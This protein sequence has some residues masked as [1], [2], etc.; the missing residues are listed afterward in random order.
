MSKLDIIS[1]TDIKILVDKFYEKVVA[2]PVIGFIFNDI[3]KLSW[4]K[5]IPVM[6]TFWSSVLLETR[7][8]TGNPMEKHLEL[9][10][11][12]PLTQLHFEQW[13]TLWENTVNE[14]FTGQVANE[15]VVR[16]KNIAR[17]MQYKIEQQN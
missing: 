14:N 9:N 12:I 5:H 7:S 2:D 15:A 16:A 6:Y 13:L 3:I 4:Q 1:E 11:M 10:K 17:L 8:Y